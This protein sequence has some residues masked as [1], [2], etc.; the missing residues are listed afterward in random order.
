M[1]EVSVDQKVFVIPD[2]GSP[3]DQWINY[4]IQLKKE[5]GSNNAKTIWLVTWSKNGTL[6]CTTNADFNKFIKRNDIDVSIA[7]TRAIADFSEIG[8]NILGMGKTLSKLFAIGV[9]LLLGSVFAVVILLLIK[10]AKK[11]DAI[12]LALLA[13]GGAGRAALAAKQLSV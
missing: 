7:A 9:P 1:A 8:G 6:S 5:V 3:C 2:S 12:D 10:A 4:F 13:T 11:T